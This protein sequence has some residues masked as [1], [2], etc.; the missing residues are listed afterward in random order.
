MQ[1]RAFASGPLFLETYRTPASFEQSTNSSSVYVHRWISNPTF[2]NVTARGESTC[3]YKSTSLSFV[4]RH[5]A[6]AYGQ[7]KKTCEL[8]AHTEE[9]RSLLQRLGILFSRRRGRRSLTFSCVI[10][11]YSPCRD[12]SGG[13]VLHSVVGEENSKKGGLSEN[14]SVWLVC[15]LEKIMTQPY[16]QVSP[17]CCLAPFCRHRSLEYLEGQA[18]ASDKM[19]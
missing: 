14:L 9:P 15:H 2:L 1:L 7:S 6:V 3:V 16:V 17:E 4:P 8:L 18:V 13:G 19:P 10:L 12:C 5:W 11:S